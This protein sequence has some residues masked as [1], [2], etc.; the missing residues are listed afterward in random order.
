[1]AI[2]FVDFWNLYQCPRKITSQGTNQQ[3]EQYILSRGDEPSSSLLTLL[4]E[5]SQ[6]IHNGLWRKLY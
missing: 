4:I 6:V 5:E 2:K 3:D 1:M